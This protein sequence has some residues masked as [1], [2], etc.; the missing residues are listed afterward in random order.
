MSPGH[1]ADEAAHRPVTP[2]SAHVKHVDP[3]SSNV[4]H[5]AQL[6]KHDPPCP[7]DAGQKSPPVAH[8]V[9]SAETHAPPQHAPFGQSRGVHPPS[10]P[11]SS[12]V[13][14]RSEASPGPPGPWAS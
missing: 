13:P 10:A 12:L 2:A 1:A 3:A 14:S 6:G 8:C 9:Q 11:A 5:A 7:E 4:E